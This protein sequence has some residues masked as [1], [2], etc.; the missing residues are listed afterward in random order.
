MTTTPSRIVDISLGFMS[1][2]QLEAAANI[3]LFRALADGPLNIAD[4]AQATAHP[5]RQ[6]RTL[7]DSMN[8]LGLLERDAG[9]YSLAPDAQAY[10]SG[11]GDIDLTPFIAFL[12]D[13]S[14][15]QWLGYDKTVAT[16][17]AGTLD[18][19]EAGW[20]KFMSGVMTYNALH[21]EQFG[22]VLDFTKYTNALDFGGLAAGFSFAAMAQNPDLKTRFVY[23]PGF[24]DSLAAEAEAAGLQDRVTIEEADT[25]TT[26]PGGEHDLV[27]LT[28]VLHRFSEADNKHIL[29]AARDSAATGATVMLIDFYLDHDERQRDIDAIHA[30]EYFNIDG[31]V[32]YPVD[33]VHDWLTETGWAPG[34]LVE[35]PGSPRVL[36]ATAV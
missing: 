25:E 16:D 32:V 33:V 8:G 12:G 15:Q 14:Y 4:L 6:V 30:G 24:T 2:K 7:A 18:L 23:A 35:L 28:H 36:L 31:T 5:Q 26:V 29:Q 9:T 21:A 11:Q 20:A 17:Q 19:D 10:L 13:I 34:E 22:R 27:L 1:A 3:G